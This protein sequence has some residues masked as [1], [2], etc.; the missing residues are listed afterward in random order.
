MI[1]TWGLSL[2]TV[3]TL[4][5]KLF[6]YSNTLLTTLNAR[7]PRNR[8][9][10]GGTEVVFWSDMPSSRTRVG[11]TGTSATTSLPAMQFAV[12]LQ[13]RRSEGGHQDTAVSLL[14][15]ALA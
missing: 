9:L 5:M 7:N 4:L 13:A 1:A 2:F 3:D 11:P 10:E 12:P 8:K 6:R 14:H 15:C